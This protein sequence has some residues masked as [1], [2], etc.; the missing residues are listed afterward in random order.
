MVLQNIVF[1]LRQFL[2]CSAYQN[3][4]FCWVMHERRIAE[5]LLRRI[6]HTGGFS[7]FTLTC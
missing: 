1:L 7:L 4:V 5:E 6:G 2:A 3:I